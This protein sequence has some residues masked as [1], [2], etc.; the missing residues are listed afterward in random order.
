ML[1]DS[2]IYFL[3]ED[4]FKNATILIFL[5]SFLVLAQKKVG[6]SNLILLAFFVSICFPFFLYNYLFDINYMYDLKVYADNIILFRE[7][8][9]FSIKPNNFKNYSFTSLYSLVPLPFLDSI[10]RIGFASKLIYLI[11]MIYLIKKKYIKNNSFMLLI[12][13]FWPSM[14]LYS[15]LGLR[16]LIIFIIS[17][18]FFKSLIEEK[19][20][21]WI[22]LL[23][24]LAL[25]KPQNAGIM[26]IVSIIYVSINYFKSIFL[27][28]IILII[29]AIYFSNNIITIFDMIMDNLN[30]YKKALYQEDNNLNNYY[31]LNYNFDLLLIFFKGAGHFIISPFLWDVKNVFQLIQSLENLAIVSFILF[32]S[33]KSFKIDKWITIFIIF[34]L[35]FYAGV[36][37]LVVSNA[38]TIARWRFPMFGTTLLMLYLLNN[39]SIKL[40]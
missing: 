27:F 13:I 4:F 10:I 20:I 9:F 2:N 15:S 33:Y 25:I 1:N 17:F 24:I 3:L 30:F 6:F 37:G 29:A 36:Y 38:G 14:I 18:F 23:A 12:L 11:F 35:F 34:T 28:L 40:K 16:E 7:L 8:D 31:E 5:F 39:K 21:T 32:Y 22:L 26:L 19:I